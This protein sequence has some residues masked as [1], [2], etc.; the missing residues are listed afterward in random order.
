MAKIAESTLQQI[1]ARLSISEVVSDYVTLSSRGG[2]LWGLCPFH[3]ERTPSFSVVDQEGFYYCFS[4]KKGGSIFDFIMETEKVPF[5]EAVKMLAQRAG[6]ELEEETPAQRAQ[7]DL[8]ENLYELYGRIAGSFHYLLKTGSSGSYARSYLKKRNVAQPMWDTF[9]LGYAP[10]DGAWLHQF[11]KKQHYSDEL[12]AQSGLFSQKNPTYPLFV[13]RLIF[14]IRNWQGK[15]V[16]FGGRDL[17]NTSKAKY[18]NTPETVIYSK[19]HN[20]FGLYE[21]LDTIKQERKAILCEGNFD[22]VALHQAGFTNAMAPLGTSFTPEQGRLL[23]RYCDTVEILFDN[24]RAG[25]EAT[26]KALLI[27]QDLGMVNKVL[28]LTNANDPSELIEQ[29]SEEALRQQLSSSLDG[30]RFLLNAQ[31]HSHDTSTAKGKARAFHQLKP[32]LRATHSEIE[33]QELIKTLSD[34]LDIDEASMH[35]EYAKEQTPKN[36]VPKREAQPVVPLNPAAISLDYYLMLTVANNPELYL[37]TRASIGFESLNDPKA[38]E[39][40]EALEQAAREDA[41]AGSEY[42]LQLLES[43]QVKSDLSSSF[44]LAE[45]RNEP[46]KILKESLLRIRL[47]SWEKKRQSNKRLLDITQLEGNDSRTI[48]EL[49]EERVEIEEEI[50]RIKQEL[51]EETGRMAS[52]LLLL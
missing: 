46:Q 17:S 28:A 10:S 52:A 40:Y 2:R 9:L 49:L 38:H 27:A 43:D 29:G 31:L 14:P 11:L 15:V 30:F 1:K 39:L 23:R 21:S 42:L 20:L 36:V 4:C 22:V 7:R 24:D 48:E 8:S 13:D 41:L 3:E 5:H 25:R 18:I 12:L 33:R 16:A 44:G 26:A 35:E 6:V 37:K 19:K 50:A 34:L 51:K 45:F 32:Y 47:R